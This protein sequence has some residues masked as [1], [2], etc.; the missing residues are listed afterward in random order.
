MVVTTG[1]LVAFGHPAM[2]ECQGSH[3]LCPT[4]PEYDNMI[5][6]VY[7]VFYIHA[8]MITYARPLAGSQ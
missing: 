8:H 5:E 3:Q 1:F 7:I 4:Y 2:L 6:Y